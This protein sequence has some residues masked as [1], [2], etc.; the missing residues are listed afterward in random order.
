M[1]DKVASSKIAKGV[2]KKR[3]AIKRKKKPERWRKENG[4]PEFLGKNPL[5]LKIRKNIKVLKI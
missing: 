4:A 5:V 1:F 2:L 3:K